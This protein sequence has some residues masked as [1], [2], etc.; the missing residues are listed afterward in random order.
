[1]TDAGHK[2]LTRIPPKERM[3]VVALCEGLSNREIG[4]KLGTTEQVAKNYMRSILR[5]SGM[6]TRLEFAVWCFRHGV[7]E[8]P[9]G[10]GHA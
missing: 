8:C 2:F 10:K 6:S 5:R 4:K 9:C 1:M 3:V 7:V